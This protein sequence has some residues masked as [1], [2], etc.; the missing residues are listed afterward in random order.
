MH[1]CNISIVVIGAAVLLPVGA[2]HA[3]QNQW[4]IQW[5]GVDRPGPEN[6]P[7]TTGYPVDAAGFEQHDP[8][9]YYDPPGPDYAELAN[10]NVGGFSAIQN[11]MQGCT[12]IGHPGGA[13]RGGH[14]GRPALPLF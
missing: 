6:L 2:V 9:S 5:N 12:G 13:C 14:G 4:L 1:K 7:F 11:L 10:V 3:Q 8:N